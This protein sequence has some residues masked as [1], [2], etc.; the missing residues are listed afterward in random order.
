MNKYCAFFTCLAQYVQGSPAVRRVFDQAFSCPSAPA[1]IDT[2]ADDDG[3]IGPAKMAEQVAAYAERRGK[4]LP[5]MSALLGSLLLLVLAATLGAQTT[6]TV[7]ATP[8]AGGASKSVTITL[9]PKTILSTF[10]CDLTEMEP[11]DVASCTIAINVAAKVGGFPINLVLPAGFSGP[12]N[13]VVVL[14]GQTSVGFFLVR[15]D[16]PPLSHGPLLFDNG[17]DRSRRRGDER[18]LQGTAFCRGAAPD[19]A[20]ARG[21]DGVPPSYGRDR[22][23]VHGDLRCRQN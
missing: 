20:V 23:L 10:T 5:Y 7:T 4:C 3:P 14:A 15:I 13:P 17:R 2:A 18:C 8:K 1:A 22:R 9:R 12:P 16:T 11:G 21:R 19:E 6:A